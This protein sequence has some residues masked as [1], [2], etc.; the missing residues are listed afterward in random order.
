M[1]DFDGVICDSGGE[2]MTAGLAV[3]RNRWPQAFSGDDGDS[4]RALASR[5]AAVN[6]RV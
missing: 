3:A 5:A 2:V 4:G 6:R 1:L